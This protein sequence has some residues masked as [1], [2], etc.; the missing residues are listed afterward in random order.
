MFASV[1]KK[2]TPVFD[3]L[4][5][6]IVETS[7]GGVELQFVNTKTKDHSWHKPR[8][9]TAEAMLSIPGASKYWSSVDDVKAHMKFL[10]NPK[11]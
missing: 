2:P 7:P 4:E 1:F 11:F 5:W 8:G 3:P 9:A 10:K 6:E